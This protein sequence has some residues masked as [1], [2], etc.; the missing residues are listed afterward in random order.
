MALSTGRAKLYDGMKILRAQWE[1]IQEVWKDPV[2]ADFEENY[3]NVLEVQ[4]QNAVRGIDRMDQVLTK[5]RRDC[6]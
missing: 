3:W 5:L 2:R 6:S 1:H 4:V